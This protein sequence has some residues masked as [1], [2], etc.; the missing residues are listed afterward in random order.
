METKK[1]LKVFFDDDMM[2]VAYDKNDVWKM[3]DELCGNDELEDNEFEE[4]P[5][6]KK[7]KICDVDDMGAIIEKTCAEWI[8]SNGRGFL[9]SM[10]W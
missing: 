5:M 8:E 4:Q 7:V 6:D 1:E 3:R 10:E 2:F 9:C